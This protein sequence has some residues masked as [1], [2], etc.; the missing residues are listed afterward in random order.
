M[1]APCG[2]GTPCCARIS[3]GSRSSVSP[4]RQPPC[5]TSR[6]VTIRSASRGVSEAAG[7]SDAADHGKEGHAPGAGQRYL[8]AVD[9]RAAIPSSRTDPHGHPDA[10]GLEAG[11]WFSRPSRLPF[12]PALRVPCIGQPTNLE[13]LVGTLSN[14]ARRDHVCRA[15]AAKESQSIATPKSSPTQGGKEPCA[16]GCGETVR[17]CRRF[18][19]QVASE[20]RCKS[21]GA[22]PASW[23][24]Y[25]MVLTVS[26]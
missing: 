18:V 11:P 25:A 14:L 3:S 6:S 1:V 10:T 21:I 24:G 26:G 5:S 19:N 2:R 4:P 7:R 23:S 8:V 12:P 20:I 13:P 17:L 9:A 16:C 15:K 22:V